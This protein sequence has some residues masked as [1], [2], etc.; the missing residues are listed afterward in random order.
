MLRWQDSNLHDKAYETRLG[1]LPVHTAK[2]AFLIGFEPTSSI[3]LP[4]SSFVAKV[5]TGTKTGTGCED[6]THLDLCV[7]QEPSPDGSPGKM[8]YGFRW[9][10]IPASKDSRASRYQYLVLCVR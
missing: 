1:P 9:L 7:K 10:I 5:D 2:L 4:Y 8:I 6:R 3:Q